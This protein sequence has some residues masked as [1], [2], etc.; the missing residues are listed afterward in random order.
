MQNKGFF[1]HIDEIFD[2]FLIHTGRN[3][4]MSTKLQKI[5]DLIPNAVY[6]MNIK[7]SKNGESM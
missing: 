6:N 7:N 2:V 5:L 3:V 1:P 4:N